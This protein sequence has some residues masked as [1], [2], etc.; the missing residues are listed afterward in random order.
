MPTYVLR[1]AHFC[2]RNLVSARAW[3]PHPCFICVCT[4]MHKIR[5]FIG[6]HRATPID[7]LL[8]QPP[9]CY[10][11]NMSASHGIIAAQSMCIRPVQSHS[12]LFEARPGACKL[13]GVTYS[14]MHHTYWSIVIPLLVIADIYIATYL[15]YASST[16]SN[17]RLGF[18]YPGKIRVWPGLL[19]GSPGH[20]GQQLW[21]GY[22]AD[23]IIIS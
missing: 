4:C 15:Q 9:G 23:P 14:T 21:S 22:N 13:A 12:H 10:P 16:N 17:V 5:P 1:V 8:F 18:S 20:P 19:S 11:Y 3:K 2:N 6:L 7:R